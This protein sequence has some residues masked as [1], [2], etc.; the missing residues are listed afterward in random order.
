MELK[1]PKT[2]E[3]S[4]NAIISGLTLELLFKRQNPKWIETKYSFQEVEE[5]NVLECR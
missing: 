1:V 5:R 4:A 2:Y 3:V